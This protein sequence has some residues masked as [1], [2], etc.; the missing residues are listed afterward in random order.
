MQREIGWATLVTLGAPTQQ[1][2][3]PSAPL[4]SS[5]GTGTVFFLKSFFIDLEGLYEPGN[6]LG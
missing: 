4:W 1:V 2:L 3:R 5:R 6:K